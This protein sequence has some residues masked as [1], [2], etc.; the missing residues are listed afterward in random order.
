MVA[1]LLAACSPSPGASRIS[2][3]DPDSS[4]GGPSASSDPTTSSGAIDVTP[5][6]T[7]ASGGTTT[8]VDSGSDKG[9]A[10]GLVATVTLGTYHAGD[11][12]VVVSGVVTGVSEAGGDCRFE[13]TPLA[14]ADNQT[15][16]QMRRARSVVAGDTS[17]CGTVSFDT[18]RLAPGKWSI[19]LAY[20]S[21]AD[22]DVRIQSAA[23]T[24][25]IS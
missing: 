7:P 17:S 24:V 12:E 23:I 5:G 2:A 6:A 10:S 22:T 16:P 9:A 13:I 4:T 20:R 18:S 15:L 19:V 3:S 14:G 11:A 25:T 1:V 21:L 8:V